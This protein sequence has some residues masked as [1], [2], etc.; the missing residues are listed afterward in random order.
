[1]GSIDVLLKTLIADLISRIGEYGPRSKQVKDFVREHQ[2]V[3]EFVDLAAACIFLKETVSEQDFEEIFRES[4]QTPG[5]IVDIG[6][7]TIF[8][9]TFPD[10]STEWQIRYDPRTQTWSWG[11]SY[12]ERSFNNQPID[13]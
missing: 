13:E 6:G 5:Q 12:G 3:D 1:M 7:L 9:S 4:L 8:V 2:R 10:K 11:K